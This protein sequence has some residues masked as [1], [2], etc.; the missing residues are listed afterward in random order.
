MPPRK[1]KF[2][3]Q[4]AMLNIAEA[5]QAGSRAPN[6]KKYSPH[7][8]QLVFHSSRKKK[9]LYIGGNR[10][11]KTTGGVC[12][13]I[14]RAT[15]THPYRPELNAIGPTRGRVAAVDFVNGVEKII[16]PQYAQWLYP[17]ALRGGAWTTAFDSY[18]KTLNFSNGSTIEFMSYDQNL[19]KFAGTSRHWVHFDEECPKP[20]YV[21]CLARLVDTNGEFW[22]TMTP[23]EGMTWIYDELY[24]PWINKPVEDRDVEII[25]IN[26]LENPY[27]SVEGIKNLIDSMDDEDTVTRIGGGF[28]QQGGRIYKNFDPTRGG[29][30]VLSDSILDPKTYFP[31]NRWMW[32]LSLDHGLNNPT[33]VL[34]HAVNDD[35]FLVT[36]DE[37]YKSDLTVEQQA[38]VIK[39]KIKEHGRF[40]DLLV[41][42]PAIVQRSALNKVSI[43]QEYQR[44]G[45][46]FTLGNNDVKSGIIRAKRYLNPV[47][48]PGD[49]SRRHPLYGGSLV[50]P[51]ATDQIT[52]ISKDG[53]YP[54][55]LID[56]RCEKLIWEK[57]RY[58]WKT[59]SD[60]KK[61]YEN[62]PYDEPHK[63]DD[64]ACDSERYALMTRPD[65][66]AN[67]NNI[68]EQQLREAM[69]EL[70]KTMTAVQNWDI[71]DPRGIVANAEVSGW[72]PGMPTPKQESEWDIDEHMGGI[73]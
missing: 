1:Q 27:L 20:I 68:S 30:H 34:W 14:W 57:K 73:W 49:K 32:I 41:A 71:A 28:V 3:P 18:T 40:P 62:N 48:Y 60:K 53:R 65:L 47:P 46:S 15:N 69:S 23:V 9:K 22:I 67:D 66:V 63:K 7:E 45:L 25:E 39:R 56:P 43:Q 21:E 44:Y 4:Q 19:D 64:H 11:G 70:D 10:S 52:Y 26:T 35:G 16:L 42:D 12:E 37:W 33:A 50:L 38:E 31:S 72:M 54:R 8:K 17:S 58:R 36:F 24:E 51:G 29:L 13:G 5:V 61:Q 59:Y 2:D 55:Q 6:I